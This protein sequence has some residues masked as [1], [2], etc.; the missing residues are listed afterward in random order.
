MSPKTRC[1][2]PNACLCDQ[3][4]RVQRLETDLMLLIARFEGC[5]LLLC[6]QHSLFADVRGLCQLR[7]Q[8]L[9][10]VERCAPERR[11]FQ[12]SLARAVQTG[13]HGEVLWKG[14]PGA[15]R[16]ACGLGEVVRNS[17]ER[18]GDQIAHVLLD[19]G[20]PRQ[21]IGFDVRFRGPL[22]HGVLPQGLLEGRSSQDLVLGLQ[23]RQRCSFE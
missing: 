3:L 23:R 6:R 12:P 19:P 16:C 14:T 8:S 18:V 4:E 9:Q 22:L 15:V 1:S 13:G 11:A 7:F 17:E 2:S 20:A 10:L 21:G 5:P